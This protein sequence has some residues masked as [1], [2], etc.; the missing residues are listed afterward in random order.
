MRNV[1][2]LRD[3]ADRRTRTLV[4]KP[5]MRQCVPGQ[6][7]G[8][9]AGGKHRVRRMVDHVL[10]AKRDRRERDRLALLSSC[11]SRYRV[12]AG[13]A[14][15]EVIEAAVL[16]DDDDDVLD[17]SGAGCVERLQRGARGGKGEGR[18]TAWCR[19]PG[20]RKDS[21]RKRRDT[22]KP[23]HI[24]R[25]CRMFGGVPFGDFFPQAAEV[26]GVSDRPGGHPAR[27]LSLVR[28]VFSL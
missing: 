5:F 19:A 2:V 4:S 24:T 28:R 11:R 9:V 10:V 27:E 13:I 18:R 14:L 7:P 16:L 8:S 23:I 1:H 21:G 20:E 12:R 15:E 17:L 25:T 26:G 6:F 3:C 22:R